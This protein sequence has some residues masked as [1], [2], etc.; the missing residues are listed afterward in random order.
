MNDKKLPFPYLIAH[1]HLETDTN[2]MAIVPTAESMAAYISSAGFYGDAT[3]YAPDGTEIAQSEG[4]EGIRRCFDQEFLKDCLMPAVINLRDND[5]P[6][7]VLE[8]DVDAE[9][10]GIQ[11]DKYYDG[12]QTGE[13]PLDEN[14]MMF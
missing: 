10:W 13:I 9:E 12:W 3:F 1:C 7:N 2:V 4:N 5:L 8:A 6:V 11:F 14:D